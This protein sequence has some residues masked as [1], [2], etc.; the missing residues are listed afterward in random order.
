M[1][2]IVPVHNAMPYLERTLESLY[3]QTL[4]RDA[5][6]VIAVDDGSTDGSGDLLDHWTTRPWRMTVLH[7]KAS[8]GPSRP[9]NAGLDL[10]TG[11]YVFFVDADDCLG[12]QAL[13][14]LV[15]MAERNDSDTVL[16]KLVG[17][18]RQVPKAVFA[19]DVDRAELASD[20]YFTLMPFKLFR[21]DLIE[22]HAIRF[23][24]HMRISEDQHFVARAYLHSRRISVVG[25]YD[26]YYVVKR[27]DDGNITSTSLDY[28]KVVEQAAEMVGLVTD[29][30]EPGPVRTHLIYRHVRVE[31]L[32]R[33]DRRF[34]E[35]DAATRAEWVELARPYARQW[36]TPEVMAKLDVAARLRVH[37]LREGHVDALVEIVR[38]DLAGRPGR[39]T[40]RDGR[41]YATVPWPASGHSGQL[42]LD[43]CD[44]T[45]EMARNSPRRRLELL[46]EE[47]TR[48]KLA[49]YAYLDQVDTDKLTTEITLRRRGTQEVLT[50]AAGQ[51]PTPHLTAARGK[52]RYDYG[53]A[54][55]EAVI[56]LATVNGGAPLPCGIWE[57]GISATARGLTATGRLGA[58]RTR[59]VAVQGRPRPL[60]LGPD[61]RPVPVGTEFDAGNNLVVRVEPTPVPAPKG[62]IRGMAQRIAHRVQAGRAT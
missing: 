36:V 7:Q 9:R 22:R 11:R 23:P 39:A 34:V 60:P 14:R 10:A 50:V 3:V 17:V 28:S 38:W 51:T 56:D 49:G 13:E 61:A 41:L 33:F 20:V 4:G 12:P 8:G 62:P 25:D 37:C 54:G 6:E 42:P 45:G 30:T 29:L 55:F 19:K 16:A 53:R 26:C 21:R 31:L 57:V 47:G 32:R 18:G 2:V 48:I 40:V 58:A 43:L 5:L 44:I 15:A 27:A 24:E 52:E 59:E 46:S 35:A 1:S